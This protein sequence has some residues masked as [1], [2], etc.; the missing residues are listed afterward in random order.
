MRSMNCFKQWLLCAAVFPLVCMVA[1]PAFAE[2]GVIEEGV[3]ELLG[4]N[5]TAM[6]YDDLMRIRG[7]IGYSCIHA[8]PVSNL[9]VEQNIEVPLCMHGLSLEESRGRV[10]EIL[11]EF[12]LEGK[13]KL[14][15]AALNAQEKH[16]LSIARAFAMPV[17]FFI[18][19]EPFRAMSAQLIGLVE[20][21]MLRRCE[22]KKSIL[23]CT[24]KKEFAEKLGAQIITLG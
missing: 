20:K 22:D 21:A 18:F 1:E 4:E 9:T 24:D 7:H 19:G 23:F 6:A 3:I 10:Q 2:E 5:I 17:D 11:K 15:L 13:A 12:H 14:R 16:L 8:P